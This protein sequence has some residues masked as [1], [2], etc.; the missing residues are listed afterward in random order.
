MAAKTNNKMAHGP[1]MRAIAPPSKPPDPHRRAFFFWGLSR[2]RHILPF[3]E[4]TS[5]ELKYSFCS[6][7]ACLPD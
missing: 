2:Y 4:K 3:F 1:V 6:H 5:P 7:Q